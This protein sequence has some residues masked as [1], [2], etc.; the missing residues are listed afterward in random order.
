MV[1]NESG[2]VISI[3]NGQDANAT[4][5]NAAFAS[6]TANNTIT[7]IQDLANVVAASGSEITNVQRELNAHASV[8]GLSLGQVYNYLFTW[9][10]DVVGSANDTIK[11]RVEAVVARFH[12]STGHTH[13]GS[14]S[15]APKI[16]A[17][18]LFSFANDAAYVSNKGSAAAAG[19]A[20][21]NS[22]TEEARV[23]AA[24]GGWMPLNRM[25]E[26]SDTITNNQVAAA[27]LTAIFSGASY[28]SFVLNYRV[29]RNTTG[30]GATELSERGIIMGVY[31]PTAATWE[32]TQTY[33]GSSGVTL[34]CVAASGQIQYTSTNMTGSAS[35]SYI[36]YTYET[37]GA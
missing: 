31:K 27:N 19:D 24:T 37:T 13:T 16:G 4:N 11:A 14:G 3:S 30:G 33:V 34:S 29:Y 36:K 35:Q 12:A 32:M 18:K 6:K 2:W 8:M 25:V 22:T 9:A 1:Q 23:Y 26:T 21:Y 15:D 7:G 28:S 17:T 10:T 5:F 20:Y